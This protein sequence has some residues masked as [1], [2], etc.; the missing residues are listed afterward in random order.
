MLS[1]SHCILS[2]TLIIIALSVLTLNHCDPQPFDG[3]ALISE[4]DGA[5]STS[6]RASAAT[7]AEDRLASLDHTAEALLPSSG[8]L[9][10][11]DVHQS[12]PRNQHLLDD[13]GW[14][15]RSRQDHHASIQGVQRGHQT[16]RERESDTAAGYPAVGAVLVDIP[17]PLETSPSNTSTAVLSSNTSHPPS[18]GSQMVQ[19]IERHSSSRGK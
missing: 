19:G 3:F 5:A 14:D 2:G 13:S 16:A 18:Q 15:D 8:S 17:L 4:A 11:E 9:T 10:G 6:A 12:H 7:E 1:L